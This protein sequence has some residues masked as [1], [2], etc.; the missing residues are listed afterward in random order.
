MTSMSVGIMLNYPKTGNRGKADKE[1]PEEREG[2][3]TRIAAA[4]F[5]TIVG[6]VLVAVGIKF[7]DN[8][9][10]AGR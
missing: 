7:S 8:G 2:S 5:G 10:S 1:K 6:P 9:R 3:L 4:V